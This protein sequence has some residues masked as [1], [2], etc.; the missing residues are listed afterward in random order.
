MKLKQ[1]YYAHVFLLS[2]LGSVIACSPTK[3]SP[4]VAQNVDCTTGCIVDPSGTQNWDQSHKV[5][6]G[7]VDILFVNDNSASMSVIQYRLAQA[8]TG[9]IQQLDNREIDYKIAMTTTDA[10][11]L[12]AAPLITFANNSTFLTRSDSNR[13]NMFN[14]AIVRPETLACENMIK[15][16]Y[17]TYGSS[18]QT[19]ASYNTAYNNTCAS[20]DERG[21]L[22]AN[23]ILTNN[24]GSFVRSDAHLNIIALS[25]EDVRSGNTSSFTAEDRASTLTSLIN[26][27]FTSKYWEFNSIIVKDAVCATAQKEAFKTQSGVTIKD[28]YG[29]YVIGA[30]PGMEYWALSSSAS[31]DIDGNAQPRGQIIS[32]CESNYSNY[33][34]NMAAKVAD[35][36]RRFDLKCSPATAP[37][38]EV[39]NNPAAT[40]PHT[41]NGSYIVFN[42]GSEGIQVRIKYTCPKTGGVQ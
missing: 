28:Q 2:A 9:F 30:N 7:K 6:T 8:F 35:S 10:T 25:N 1:L 14:A 34:N 42:R 23:Y 32:I 31:Q 17:N 22:T 19:L 29:N 36:A 18:F 24:V 13:A 5:G 38:V 33:F 12:S 4:S 20:G 15:S 16:Y 21:V 41:W 3:F 26:T 37:V 40:V 11:K 27:K 39:I